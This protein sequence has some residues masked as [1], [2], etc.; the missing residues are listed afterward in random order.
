MIQLTD[1]AKF[2]PDEVNQTIPILRGVTFNIA[3]GEVVA[4]TGT[5]GCGKTTLLNILGTLDQDYS[6]RVLIDGCDP[7]TMNDQE[8]SKF[9]ASTVGFVFQQ[10]NLS[11][12]E[13][14]LSN[15][16][17]PGWFLPQSI[18]TKAQIH[19]AQS[20]LERMGLKGKEHHLPSQLSG[21]ERQRVAIARALFNHP[22]IILCDEPTGNL[23]PENTASI[24]QCFH[25]LAK[26]EGLTVVIITHDPQV[27][28]AAQRI[29]TIQNGQVFERPK[30][31]AEPT[32][33][34][35]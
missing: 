29:L 19:R 2:Y 16:L 31:C 26:S 20:L 34:H 35:R 6:G 17:T 28:A 27:A 30:S 9:R 8:L 23:D 10:F 11:P 21:G 14:A 3:K 24:T 18:G 13:T 5:S 22:K 1:I 32:P 33:H 12:Q 15:V 25:D 7:H 4:I